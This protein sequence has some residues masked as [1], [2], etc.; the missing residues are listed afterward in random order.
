MRA[1][2][3]S[4]PSHGTRIDISACA[5]PKGLSRDF[6]HA[7][8]FALRHALAFPIRAKASRSY[9]ARKSNVDEEHKAEHRQDEQAA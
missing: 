6:L 2:M 3:V 8:G 9:R 5:E 4:A 1:Y 7:N